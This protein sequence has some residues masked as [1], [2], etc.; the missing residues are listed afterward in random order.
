MLSQCCAKSFAVRRAEKA[1]W[2]RIIGEAN[3]QACN[4]SKVTV[5]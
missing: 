1:N 4:V 3:R 5:N 2:Y